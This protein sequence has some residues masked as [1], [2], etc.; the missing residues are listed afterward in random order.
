MYRR[1]GSWGEVSNCSHITSCNHAYL[2][3]RGET[4]DAAVSTS[5]VIDGE[6]QAEK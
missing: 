1:R 2:H 6:K 3:D 4:E 5:S